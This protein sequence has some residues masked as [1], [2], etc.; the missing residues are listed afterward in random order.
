MSD[1]VR[2]CQHECNNVIKYDGVWRECQ[3][4]SSDRCL[5]RDKKGDP[6]ED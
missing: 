2:A 3:K 5:V 1:F 4:I 6:E